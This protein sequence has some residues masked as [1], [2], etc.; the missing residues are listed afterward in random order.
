MMSYSNK[1]MRAICLDLAE[2]AD[3]LEAEA[4]RS[5]ADTYGSAPERPERFELKFRHIVIAL[6]VTYAIMT[7]A[8][9]WLAAGYVPPV[10][11]IGAAVEQ[12]MDLQRVD[13]GRYASRTFKFAYSQSY[14]TDPVP[15]V[16]YEDLTPLPASNYEFQQLSPVNLTRT[17]T[18]KT[19]DGSSPNT[20][21]RRY[22]VV[23]PNKD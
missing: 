16:V 17:V 14:Q 1:E 3:P 8:Y 18:L 23:L 6:A 19:S 9:F 15:L 10:D 20:N 4:L 2:K 11:P 22:F 13:G 5:V 7:P 12:I 21:G